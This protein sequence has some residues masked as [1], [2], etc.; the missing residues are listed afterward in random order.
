MFNILV[1]CCRDGRQN[2]ILGSPGSSSTTI[3]LYVTITIFFLLGLHYK[4]IH[5]QALKQKLFK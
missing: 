4:I 3:F 5:T 1:L 2:L